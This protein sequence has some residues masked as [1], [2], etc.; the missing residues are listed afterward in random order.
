MIRNKLIFN[1]PWGCWHK[2]ERSDLY[3]YDNY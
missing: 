3:Y 1:W 2:Q